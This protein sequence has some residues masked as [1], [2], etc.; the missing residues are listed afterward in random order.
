MVSIITPVRNGVNYIEECINSV[1]NQSYTCVE[2][3]I[4]DGVST[5]GTM[6]IVAKYKAKYPDRISFISEKDRGTCD[7]WNKGWLLAKGQ[8]FGWLGSDDTY[9][10]DSVMTAVKFFKDNPDARLIFGDTNIVDENGKL[11]SRVYSEDF[12]LKRAITSACCMY[13]PSVFYKREV[14]ETVGLMDAN[15]GVCD[16]DFYIRAGKIFKFYRIEQPLSNFRIHKGSDTGRK[17]YLLRYARENYN[18]AKRYGA[19]I[20]SPRGRNYILMSLTHPIH[21][22]IISIYNSRL[23]KPVLAPI[24]HMIVGNQGKADYFD[25]GSS[26]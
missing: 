24:F 4:V 2:H 21:P 18:V 17:D 13:S 26:S 5:D 25:N 14:V 19:T 3:V 10:P 16:L 1:L 7:G 11:M 12:D 23:L 20:F 8:I 9:P 15:I 6:D 22:L